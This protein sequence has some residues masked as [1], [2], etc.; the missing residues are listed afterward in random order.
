MSPVTGSFVSVSIAERQGYGNTCYDCAE[1]GTEN[2][3]AITALITES[4][5]FGSEYCPMCASCRDAYVIERD[6]AREEEKANP[7]GHCDWCKASNVLVSPHRDF[8]EGI[9][10]RVY[11]VCS[12]C[13]SKER[14]RIAEEMEDY[15][16]DN[17]DWIGWCD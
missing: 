9:H 16:Y 6:K 13:L 14:D 7:T 15:E 3:P 4:D 11:D 12:P 8:E 5:S 1:K 2:V 10:G 17:D